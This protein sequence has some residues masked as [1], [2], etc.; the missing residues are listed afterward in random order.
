M[1]RRYCYYVCSTG[2]EDPRGIIPSVVYEGEP[3]HY[4]LVGRGTAATPWFWGKTLD[5]AR[6]VCREQN[7]R[8]GLSP[9]DVNKIVASSMFPR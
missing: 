6:K 5:E 3:G 2:Q 1:D 9:E 7:E 4:P 8:L